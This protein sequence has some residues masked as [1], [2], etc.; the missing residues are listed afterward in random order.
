MGHC[1]RPYLERWPVTA[2]TGSRFVTF[3]R[4]SFIFRSKTDPSEHS[5]SVSYSTVKLRYSESAAPACSRTA[6]RTCLSGE[7][8]TMRYALLCGL[9]CCKSYASPVQAARRPSGES[10]A[11]APPAAACT[12]HDSLESGRNF[13]DTQIYLYPVVLYIFIC[14]SFITRVQNSDRGTHSHS[15][16][17]PPATPLILTVI[18]DRLQ[19][20]SFSQSF[21]TPCNTTHSHTVVVQSPLS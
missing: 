12:V 21:W 1:E 19:H 13:S 4:G 18:L 14:N 8:T 17:G 11:R 20:H 3:R 2:E 6:A 15:H 7:D 9:C 16:F 5:T 10:A